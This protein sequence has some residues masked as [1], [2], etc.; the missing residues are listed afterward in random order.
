[1]EECLVWAT[2]F[3]RY[4]ESSCAH[5]VQLYAAKASGMCAQLH[6]CTRTQQPTKETGTAKL[7]S[8]SSPLGMK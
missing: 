5:A 8:P 1:M 7:T 4:S 6:Q 2:L 3:S